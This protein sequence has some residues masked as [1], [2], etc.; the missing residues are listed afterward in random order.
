LDIKM[1]FKFLRYPEKMPCDKRMHFMVGVVA[2]AILTVF[3][4]N[5]FVVA[6]VLVTV[7]WGIELF[8]KITKSGT[9]DNYDAL[10]VMVGGLTVYLSY[11]IGG[12]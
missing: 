4:V 5:V 3:T 10:A 8:Q 2:V 9:Y 1:F 6:P 11:I 12:L 7:S